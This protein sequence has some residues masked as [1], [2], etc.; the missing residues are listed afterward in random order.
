MTPLMIGLLGFLLMFLLIAIGMPIAFSM[1]LAGMLG[2]WV[3]EGSNTAL[4]TVGML[5]YSWAAN[6]DFMCIPLFILMG[7]FANASGLIASAYLAAYKWVGRLPGGLAIASIL[8]SG[9]FGAL[10][11]SSSASAAT[12]ATICIPEMEK[13]N[14][15]PKLMTGSVAIGGTLAIL[16]PPSVGMIIY[17]LITEESIGRLF[18]AG[19]L[20]GILMVVLLSLTTWGLCKLNPK[21]GP[22]GPGSS[23]K[24]KFAAL[25][26]SW[27]LG[28]V[29]VMVL[30][31]ISLGVFTPTEAAAVG[32]L[33][34][35]LSALF[36]GAVSLKSLFQAAKATA[37]LTVMIFLLLIGA[38]I[39]N[40]FMAFSGFSEVM[41]KVITGVS[42][43]P[44]IILFMIL[45]T[46]FLFGA[47][48]DTVAMSI[49]LL[50]LY[51][52]IVT[53]LGFN[54]VWFGVVTMVMA[55]IALISPPIGLNCFVVHGAF[56]KYSLET[57]FRGV[58]PFI[59]VQ[60]V[61]IIILILFPQLSLFLPNI[62]M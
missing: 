12:M 2:I 57:I 8:G 59:L 28:L 3:L 61:F 33:I 50:P 17:G 1:G 52:P 29:F 46:Y 30:G 41:A 39:F 42:D 6:H 24:E 47:I 43:N 58:L 60:L 13:Y 35:F 51:Y 48:M 21:L 23:F 18:I 31:G 34:M 49:L 54:G 14:Y 26:R 44:Y 25:S 45:I 37:R 36:K 38:M 20:P 5:P 16:I 22:P 53:S 10:S 27:E 40:T 62:L 4:V 9:A 11:G 19:V 56:P 32:A 55:E 15:A 7:H